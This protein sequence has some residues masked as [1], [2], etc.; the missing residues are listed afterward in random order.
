MSAPSPE[1]RR[2]GLPAATSW[3]VVECIDIVLAEP[4]RRLG[5]GWAGAVKGQ[6][7]PDQRQRWASRPSLKHPERGGLRVVNHLVEGLDRAVGY[8][9]I[10]EAFGPDRHRR[11]P[12]YVGQ[13]RDQLPAIDHALGVRAKPRFLCQARPA[14]REAEPAKQIV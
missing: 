6:R 10:I 8:P 7:Q 4:G 12:E 5:K 1:R 14:D 3:T 9:G 13:D 11:R 2:E